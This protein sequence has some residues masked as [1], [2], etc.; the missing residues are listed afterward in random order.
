MRARL[1]FLATAITLPAAPAMAGMVISTP[2]PE[3]GA[4]LAA[5]ALLS[6]GYTWMR[7]RAR[8]G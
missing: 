4:G 2:G 8:R 3:A 5:L 6:A 1:I 7:V